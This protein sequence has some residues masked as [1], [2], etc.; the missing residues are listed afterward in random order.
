MNMNGHDSNATK[1][2]VTDLI[3]PKVTAAQFK[4]T[5]GTY[6]MFL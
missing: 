1:Q 3:D 6:G 4:H 2:Q 5:F